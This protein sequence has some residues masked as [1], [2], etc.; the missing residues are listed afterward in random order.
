MSTQV[1]SSFW[2]EPPFSILG[3]KDKVILPIIGK[4]IGHFLPCRKQAWE[5][6]ARMAT[7]KHSGNCCFGN[8]SCSFHSLCLKISRYIH[9]T[10]S[11]YSLYLLAEN[12]SWEKIWCCT[13]ITQRLRVG[14]SAVCLCRS[15]TNQ[16]SYWY[17]I[18][19]LFSHIYWNLPPT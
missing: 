15:G 7:F 9:S 17:I 13:N 14:T 3:K 19:S 10:D 5:I 8:Q 16:H 2:D 11:C 12:F 1:S 4:I 6:A 18:S